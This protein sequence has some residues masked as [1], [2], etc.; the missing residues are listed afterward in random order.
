MGVVYEAEPIAPGGPAPTDRRVA[1]KLLVFPPLLSDEEREALIIR[2]AREARALALV[3]HP[4]VVR[5]Y[6]VDQVEGQPYLVMEY[7]AGQNAREW[8]LR[9]GPL[10]PDQVI[11]LRCQ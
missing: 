5:V 9:R 3:R 10:P 1:L 11:A 6:D 7:L 4:N 8:L 2:F